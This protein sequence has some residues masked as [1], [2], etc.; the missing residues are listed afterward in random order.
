MRRFDRLRR[1]ARRLAAKNGHELG[2]FSDKIREC[3]Y[4]NIIGQ[5][6]EVKAHWYMAKC[7]YCDMEAFIAEELSSHENKGFNIW[8]APME[9]AAVKLT[10][11][12]NEAAKTEGRELPFGVRAKGVVYGRVLLNKC[13]RKS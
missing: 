11:M 12:E 5:N 13:E 3:H 2:H 7:I 6:I 10:K 8:N 9:V 4:I 1:E